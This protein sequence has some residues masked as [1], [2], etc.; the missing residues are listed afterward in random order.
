MPA[1]AE[2]VTTSG[3]KERR[4]QSQQQQQMQLKHQRHQQ[5]QQ[6]TLARAGMLAAEGTPGSASSRI[7]YLFLAR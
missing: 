4:R 1:T 5:H 3:L 7:Q 6:G 2:T